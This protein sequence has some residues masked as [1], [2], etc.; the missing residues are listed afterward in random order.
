ME[1]MFRG[2]GGPHRIT[3]VDNSDIYKSDYRDLGCSSAEKWR[4]LDVACSYHDC[5]RMLL[6]CTECHTAPCKC[7]VTMSVKNK[8]GVLIT[9]WGRVHFF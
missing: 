2:A 3:A 7:V 1:R 9:E 6:L 8:M 4:I 5:H